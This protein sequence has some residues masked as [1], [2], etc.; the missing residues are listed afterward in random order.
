MEK[1]NYSIHYKKWH[2]DTKEHFEASSHYYIRNLQEKLPK[3]KEIKILD[4]GCGYGIGMYALQ[5]M[6]YVNVSGIDISPDQIEV[7][8]KH[9]LEVLL[10]EDTI[11]WLGYN[12][13]AYDVILLFDVLEHIPVDDQ[14]EFLYAISGALKDEGILFCSVPNA[15]STFATR[16]LFIDWTHYTSFSEHS[17]EFILLNSGFS[18]IEVNEIEFISK[19]RYPWLIRKSVVRW[20]FLKF[21]RSI[22]RLQAIAEL[23]EEGKKI[24]LSLNLFAVANK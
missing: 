18:Y 10:V 14:R 22:R 1:I 5:K 24:P 16:W 12:K 6:G 4:V 20:L 23:G 21:F 3:N 17:L 2:N 13:D 11:R 9:N 15:N 19:P 7:A 8:M